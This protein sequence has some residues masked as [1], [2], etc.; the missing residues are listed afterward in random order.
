MNLTY[1]QED[2]D[3]VIPDSLQQKTFNE[4]RTAFENVEKDSLQKIFYAKSYLAKAIKEK[5]KLNQM[6]GYE[7][8]G[9]SFRTDYRKSFSYFDKGIAVSKDFSNERYPAIFY[10]YKGAVLQYKGKYKESL[11]N[12]LEAMDAADKSGNLELYYVNKYN[13]GTVKWRLE[14]YQEALDIYKE[15]YAFEKNNPKRDTL[16]FMLSHLALANLYIE[17][18]Q[19]DSAAFYI[20]KGIRIAAFTKNPRIYNLFVLNEGMRL[21]YK[22]QYLT[23]IDS[24]QKTIPVLMS[25]RDKSCIIDAYF[26]LGKAHDSLQ[27]KE[28]AIVYY[29]KVDSV[30]SEH[31]NFIS[32]KVMEN[33]DALYQYYKSQN[34]IQKQLHYTNRKLF[35]DSIFYNNYR[36]LSATISKK[37]DRRSLLS[38]QE[39]LNAALKKKDRKFNVFLKIAGAVFCLFIFLLALF[40]YKQQRLK[41]RFQEFVTQHTQKSTLIPT[42]TVQATEE[43]IG[44]PQEIV[45]HLLK[46]LATF[47]KE[48]AYIHADITLTDLAKKFK[49]NSAYLSKVINTFKDKN[50]AEYLNDLRVDYAIDKIQN[51]KHFLLYTIKA[52]ALEVGF[53]NSQS[54]ARA[55]KRKTKMQ[56]SDFIKQVKNI[57]I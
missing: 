29:K 36:Y 48:T 38:E 16:D 41:R 2:S 17:T 33:Y 37:F 3:F 44:I 27:Q 40:Y 28:T 19:L 32:T 35:A 46:Q 52:I 43:T 15:C 57:T 26:H 23:A 11:D 8:L 4:L 12:Y 54:F 39:K 18:K 55:F 30:F 9:K 13:I 10:T 51:D 6:I 56:P 1:A 45:D 25:D 42:Q 53:N 24:I 5:D 20:D 34:D 47:E 14:Q 21:F 49:T 50:F 7:F 31:T 22:K